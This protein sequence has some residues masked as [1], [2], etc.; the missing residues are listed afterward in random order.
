MRKRGTFGPTLAA[1]LLASLLLL[2]TR[3]QPAPG[4]TPAD[5]KIFR[6]LDLISKK[7]DASVV[8]SGIIPRSVAVTRNQE[9]ACAI[10][11]NCPREADAR[12]TDA[13]K[14][15]TPGPGA[16]AAPAGSGAEAPSGQLLVCDL[17]SLWNPRFMDGSFTYANDAGYDE[18]GGRYEVFPAAGSDTTTCLLGKLLFLAGRGPAGSA[19]RSPQDL[20]FQIAFRRWGAT[21]LAPIGGS[22]QAPRKFREGDPGAREAKEQAE[23]HFDESPRWEER[24][25][26][27][28]AFRNGATDNALLDAVALFASDGNEFLMAI[29]LRKL[30]SP[31]ATYFWAPYHYYQSIHLDRHTLAVEGDTEAGAG[32]YQPATTIE[33][34]YAVVIGQYARLRLTSPTGAPE[35]LLVVGPCQEC[36]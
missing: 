15:G 29:D 32:G 24:Y 35:V 3:G 27:A 16:P 11:I 12:G 1:A 7:I 26:T 14:T 2:P 18:D 22:Q 4:G 5:G 8:F 30:E 20:S 31:Q 34:P 17:S 6:I 23:R 21:Y 19:L 13:P 36:P 9:G 10:C 25:R 33:Y 28:W